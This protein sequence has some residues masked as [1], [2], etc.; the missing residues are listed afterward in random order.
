LKRL[1]RAQRQEIGIAG[2]G[3]DQMH[4]AALLVRG[5][6]KMPEQSPAPRFHFGLTET[7]LRSGRR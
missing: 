5:I 3:A 1:Q 4:N 2:A 7:P 6:F